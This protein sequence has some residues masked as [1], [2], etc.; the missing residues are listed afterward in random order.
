MSYDYDTICVENYCNDFSG[1]AWNLITITQPAYTTTDAYAVIEANVS[2]NPIVIT[3]SSVVRWDNQVIWIRRTD[4]NATGNSLTVL[5][6][7]GY[8]IMG[9]SSFVTN[10]QNRVIAIQRDPQGPNDWRTLL[11]N[12]DQLAPTSAKGD[13]I[14]NNGTTNVALPVGPNGSV[15][16]ASSTSPDGVIWGQTA[17]GGDVTGPGSSTDQAIARFNGTSGKVIQNSGVI[18]DNSNNISGAVN[19]VSSGLVNGRNVAA[20]G[21]TLDNH[22]SN[23]NNPHM[24]TAAQVGN[25]VA[26]WNA[27]E[28]QGVSISSTTPT[29]TQV[30]AYNGSVWIPTTLSVLTSAAENLTAVGGGSAI[31]PSTSIRYTYVT[32]TGSGTAVGTL[33]N[34]SNSTD[35]FEKIVV[36]A[37]IAAGATFA[38]TVTSL[39][40][41]DGS[42]GSRLVTF[43]NTGPSI[44]L[45]WKQSSSAWFIVNTGAYLSP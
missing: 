17:G 45:V 8:T 33:A 28:L 10:E 11:N 12:F 13:I 16:I 18:I 37:N 14:V 15:L 32:V 31:N 38:L 41:A 23:F 3:L 39:V 21:T 35:N 5:P 22:V 27:S 44:Y 24:T 19:Y 7:P 30:L 4:P 25:T 43:A 42:T 40:T 36:A 1:F 34:G 2:L 20:D 26:Q 9:S 6:Q 29:S